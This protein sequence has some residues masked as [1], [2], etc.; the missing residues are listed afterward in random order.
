MRFSSRT[1][2][3]INCH[4][5]VIS[6]VGIFDRIIRKLGHSSTPNLVHKNSFSNITF[7]TFNTFDCAVRFTFITFNTF[8]CWTY[9]SGGVVSGT[10]D[11]LRRVQLEATAL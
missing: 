2:V 11:S 4:C 8:D 5:Y 1:A 9:C 3:D 7:I 10:L 6:E